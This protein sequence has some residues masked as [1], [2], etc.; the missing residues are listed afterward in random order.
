[1]SLITTHLGFLAAVI[2]WVWLALFLRPNLPY[3]LRTEDSSH[4]YFGLAF[5]GALGLLLLEAFEQRWL[6]ENPEE[7]PVGLE[8]VST[9]QSPKAKE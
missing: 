4:P 7:H 3:I 6:I 1:L 2:G 5:L 9:Q 8:S